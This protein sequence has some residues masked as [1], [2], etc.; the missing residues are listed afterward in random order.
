MARIRVARGSKNNLPGALDENALLYGEMYWEREQ[1]DDS[2]DGVSKGVLYMGQPDGEGS[3]QDPMAIAG[4]RAMQSLYFQGLW[5]PSGGAYPANAQIGDI[6]VAQADGGGAAST[7]KY[8]DWAVCI[9]VSEDGTSS[10]L[11]AINQA[12]TTEDPLGH[13]RNPLQLNE[14]VLKLKYDPATLRIN[15]NGELTVSH[16]EVYTVESSVS[17]PEGTPVALDN[18]GKAII[19]DAQSVDTAVV[20]GVASQA[21]NPGEFVTVQRADLVQSASYAFTEIGGPVYLYVSGAYTQD[22]ENIQP[23]MILQQVGIAT[24]ADTI[25]VHIGT[26]FQVDASSDIFYIPLTQEISETDTT[27]APSSAAVFDLMQQLTNVDD[28]LVSKTKTTVQTMAGGLDILGPVTIE[29]Q[30]LELTGGNGHIVA[31]NITAK[32][33]L[34]VQGTITAIN[35]T[36]AEIADNIVRINSNQTGVP[37]SVLESGFEV[38]RGDLSNYRII[39][40]ESSDT[41]KL[42]LIGNEQA[43]ATRADIMG[44]QALPVWDDTTKR[45]ISTGVTVAAGIIEPIGVSTSGNTININGIDLVQGLTA[46]TG[47]GNLGIDAN[48]YATKVYNAVWN[49]IA[50][51]IPVPKHTTIQYGRAYVM[52]ENGEYAVSQSYC[53]EGLIGIASDTYG[54]GVGRVERQSQMPIAIGGFVLAYVDKVYRTGTPLTAGPSGILTEISAQDKHDYPERILATFWKDES[55]MEWNGINVDGRRWVKIR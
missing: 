37:S 9:D 33:N 15:D 14:G 10:W 21:A 47:E 32:G 45:F 7:F 16:V 44:D 52:D 27:H 31:E 6:Y 34:D 28:Q 48:L 22:V 1:T 29:N 8:G 46:P 25:D 12:I 18:T 11:K 13:D 35:T 41:F 43:I 4:A 54:I 23:G 36:E 40:V 39:F 19:A 2:G 30:Q 20:I 49:D 3:T 24:A 26:P 5:D 42:G 53:P 38:E 51:F 17:I 50:D 55:E